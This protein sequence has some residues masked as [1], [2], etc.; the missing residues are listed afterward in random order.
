MVKV[1]QQYHP[2]FE[3]HSTYIYHLQPHVLV[4]HFFIAL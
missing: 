2:L 1:I 3:V 4:F